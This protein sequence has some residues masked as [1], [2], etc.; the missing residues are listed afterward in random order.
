[1]ITGEMVGAELEKILPQLKSGFDKILASEKSRQTQID[2]ME[3]FE[4]ELK[5]EKRKLG[6]LE[7]QLQNEI[8]DGS[9]ED[10][11]L[12]RQKIK[13]AKNKIH[14]LDSTLETLREAPLPNPESERGF[15]AS[16]F[17]TLFSP[18]MESCVD[19]LVEDL[20]KLSQI[21]DI[22]S[23]SVSEFSVEHDIRVNMSPF[24]FQQAFRRAQGLGLKQANDLRSF[25][26]TL[27]ESFDT[28]SGLKF[29]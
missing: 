25:L 9:P 1:M 10:I 28:A 14:D 18:F 7:S 19:D 20:V 4:T 16:S 17:L 6:N 5:S 3:Q 11:S 15:L 12:L 22:L 26:E 24:D 8:S 29:I 21:E 27:I 2:R 13:E 23:D